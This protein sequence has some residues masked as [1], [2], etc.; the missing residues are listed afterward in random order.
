M[1]FRM[2]EN[3]GFEVLV[4]MEEQDDQMGGIGLTRDRIDR[5]RGRSWVFV[6]AVRIG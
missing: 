3:F 2:K 6:Y 1:K 4:V 5:L